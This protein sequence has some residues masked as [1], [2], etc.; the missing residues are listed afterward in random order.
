MHSKKGRIKEEKVLTYAG[1]SLNAIPSNE[2]RYDQQAKALLSDPQILARIIKGTVREYADVPVGEI[3]KRLHKTVRTDVPVNAGLTNKVQLDSEAGSIPNEGV[4]FFDVHT[5][6]KDP[7]KSNNAN[8]QID[9]EVQ[10]RLF[11]GYPLTYRIELYL[12]RMISS[13]KGPVMQGSE[14][15]SLEKVYSIWICFGA[16]KDL[17][18]FIVRGTRV[19]EPISVPDTVSD[20]D[21]NKRLIA[22]GFTADLS[23]YVIVFLPDISGPSSWEGGKTVGMLNALFSTQLDLQ[24]K[25]DILTKK[26]GVRMTAKIRKEMNSVGSIAKV[27]ERAT[28]ERCAQEYK[29]QLSDMQLHFKKMYEEMY[30]E[31]LKNEQEKQLQRMRLLAKYASHEE[32]SSM[33][34][35]DFENL[36]KKYHIE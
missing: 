18:N 30:K 24:E 5:G 1:E 12:A 2:S 9:L 20:D 11:P 7:E 36:C 17:E 15:G 4:I 10:N 29:Q 32:L 35:E 6:I 8:I 3:V 19:F 22:H 14:Y 27:I 28:E 16:P 25:Q 13:Q 33:G 23:S 21:L 34:K 26:Y 31:Q